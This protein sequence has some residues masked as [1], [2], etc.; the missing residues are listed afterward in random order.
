MYIDPNRVVD[1]DAEDQDD[2]KHEAMLMV[3]SR[4]GI[5]PAARNDM[6]D[7]KADP[8]G[9]AHLEK[10]RQ[11][12]EESGGAVVQQDRQPIRRDL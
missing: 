2:A 1:E 5:R 4:V 6:G 8:E 10:Q 3:P 7:S 9:E 12:H 11:H